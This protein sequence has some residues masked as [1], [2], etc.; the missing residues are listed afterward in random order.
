MTFQPTPRQLAILKA[1]LLL[2]TLGPAL[3]YSYGLWADTLGANPI[4]ALTR[5]MGIWTLNFL[6]LT[7]CVTPLRKL[8]G[9]HWLLRL[10]RQLGLTTFAYGVLHLLTY[11]WL[12][13][14]WDV[15]AIAK[16]VLKRPFITVG[17]AAFVLMLPLALTS[18]NGAIR[19]LGGKRWQ[20]LHRSVYAVAMLGVVHY[21]WLVK[22]VAL[23]D[24]IIYALVLASL[25]GWRIMD[26]IRLNGPWPGRAPGVEVR[27][28]VFRP[29]EKT[30]PD[31]RHG[32]P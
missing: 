22:R 19:R 32:R 6:L 10:R 20:S 21:L 28:I 14:F 24:P 2:L 8:S 3:R 31:G 7:L 29:Y 13:Q 26:R 15:A 5:G 12:D 27:P 23:L 25:L 18:S 9:M 11:L 1:L 30:A 17:F 16:D 4:E